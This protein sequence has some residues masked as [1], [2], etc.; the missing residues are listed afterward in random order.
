MGKCLSLSL[1]FFFLFINLFNCFCRAPPHVRKFAVLVPPSV[2]RWAEP[3]AGSHS[4]SSDVVDWT[5]MTVALEC[6]RAARSLL[7][8]VTSWMP[9]E[10]KEGKDAHAAEAALA[11]VETEIERM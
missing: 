11:A 5:D 2:V 8:R 1:I 7:Q 3:P 4:A 6:V 9:D 10:G